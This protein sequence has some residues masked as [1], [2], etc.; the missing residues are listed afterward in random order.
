MRDTAVRDRGFWIGGL[1]DVG[2]VDMCLELL[3]GGEDGGKE[4]MNGRLGKEFFYCIVKRK[5][6]K[7]KLGPVGWEGR[8]VWNLK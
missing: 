3:R 4:G 1:K 8:G 7:K 5:K 2:F 6:K